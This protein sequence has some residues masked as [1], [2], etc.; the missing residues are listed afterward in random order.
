L[1][2]QAT[3]LANNQKCRFS[4]TIKFSVKLSNNQ[5]FRLF[6]FLPSRG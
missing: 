6:V 3:K 4:E 5:K 1:H 2:V